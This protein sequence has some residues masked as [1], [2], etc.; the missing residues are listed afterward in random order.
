MRVLFFTAAAIAALLADESQ[1]VKL[2]SS[3]TTNLDTLADQREMW[4]N[5]NNTPA[6]QQL[7]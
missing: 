2:N 5:Y 3:L 7:M 4:G 6:K 1:A